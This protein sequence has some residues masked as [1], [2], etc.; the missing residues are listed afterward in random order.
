[1]IKIII[2]DDEPVIIRGLRKLIDW[3]AV[4]IEVAGTY[5]D[6]QSSLDGILSLRPDIA[7]L[8]IAMPKK[9][10]IQILSKLKEFKSETQVIFIS[11]YQNFSYAQDAVKYGAAGYLLKPVNQDELMNALEKCLLAI[12]ERMD[13]KNSPKE[14]QEYEKD[15]PYEKL[16]ALEDMI[17]LPAQI[18]ILYAKE[19]TPRERHLIAFSV[20]SFWEQVLEIENRGI[21]F[22][23]NNSI[24]VVL[25]G[26]NKSEGKALLYQLRSLAEQEKHHVL[27][28]IVG[29]AVNSMSE[30]PVQYAACKEMQG[31]FYFARYLPRL[32]MDV[33]ER[34]FA[35]PG[36]HSKLRVY[37]A[38]MQQAILKQST[39]ECEQGFDKFKKAVCMISD[40]R[41]EDACYHFCSCFWDMEL[42]FQSMGMEEIGIQMKEMLDKSRSFND[43]EALTGYFRDLLEKYRLLVRNS[44][45]G[46]DKK[47]I[48]RAKEYIEQHY[49]ENVTLEVLAHEIHMNPYY[50]S[51]FF[52]K[53]A[54]KNFKDY[55]NEIRMEHAVTLLVTTD[56]MAYEIASEVGYRDTRTFSEMFHRIFGETPSNYRKRI[57]SK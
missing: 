47:D 4:G 54:G 3:K 40:G 34:V 26:M 11:G 27:G 2:A 50:F 7:L 21:V 37:S 52:K 10:G 38:G 57:L 22:E 48:V 9:D 31:Y 1:M 29:K 55:L 33:E 15:M 14:E 41:K 44:L 32:M 17:Y 25:K 5:E 36:E 13:W 56:K 39:E 43:Y 24:I 51:A 49:K 12:Q 42:K 16:D 6:G 23:K 35:Y 45:L 18:V 20:L 46:S 53:Q 30:I 8:D 28:I 19:E